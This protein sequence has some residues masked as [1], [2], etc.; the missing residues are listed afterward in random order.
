M[1]VE[2]T[3]VSQKG[4]VVIPQ[5]IRE[6]LGIKTGTRLAVF[7]AGDTVILKKIYIPSLEEEFLKVAQETIA[8]AK[9]RGVT[10]DD[11]QKEVEAYRA[12]KRKKNAK[13][14]S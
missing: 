2:L 7:G 4:Q 13:G 12:E 10:E 3:K 5:E 6:K 11:V 9:K 1:N 14:G 8:I